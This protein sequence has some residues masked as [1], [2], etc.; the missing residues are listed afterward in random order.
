MSGSL[1]DRLRES[2]L[3]VPDFPKSGVLYRD[4]TPILRDPPLFRE[5]VDALADRYGNDDVELVCGIEARGFIFG[6]AVAYRCSLPFIPIRWAGKLPREYESSAFRLEYGFD[7]HEVHRDA[8]DGGRRVLLVDDLLGTGQ[9]LAACVR[10]VAEVGGD[11]VA[12]A[13]VVEVESL[14]GR[15]QLNGLDLTS[16]CRV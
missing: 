14:E 6:A 12:A 8:F 11:P 4:V 15:G 1:A 16:L 10:S 3:E 7:A 9:T 2:V 5:V 13:V